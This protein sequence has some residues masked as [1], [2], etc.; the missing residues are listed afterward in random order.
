M[1]TNAGISFLIKLQASPVLSCEFCNFLR[2]RFLQNTRESVSVTIITAQMY[3]R[4]SELKFCAG[5]HLGFVSE[6]CGGGNLQLLT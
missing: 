3:S 6:V 4:K 2:A 5:S 1:E